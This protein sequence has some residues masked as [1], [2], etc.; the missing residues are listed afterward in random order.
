MTE[1]LVSAWSQARAAL[2]GA[3]IEEPTFDARLLVELGAGVK[4]HDILTDPRRELSDADVQAI[5]ALVA[6]R[7]QREPMSHILGE[8]GFRSLV[9]KVTRDVLTPRPET[10]LLVHLALQNMPEDKPLRVLDFGVGSGAILAAI[11]IERPLATGVGVDVSEAAVLLAQ[12]NME[13]LELDARSDVV[14]GDWGAGIEGHFDVIVSN[15]PYIPSGDIAGLMPEVS[16]HEP[17]LAL[18]GGADGLDAYRAIAPQIPGLL[19]PGGLAVFEFGVGQ[20]G[21]V[22]A[23]L[24]GAGLKPEQLYLDLSGKPRAWTARA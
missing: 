6:R 18:D 5:A 1:T 9:L 2:E 17:R 19:A 7:V 15:P 11:L 16:V 24:A 22:R 10:E 23:V 3:G 8:K 20:E 14:L 4:R 13:A 21:A 12:S